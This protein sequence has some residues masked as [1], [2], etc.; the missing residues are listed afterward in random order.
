MSLDEKLYVNKEKLMRYRYILIAILGIIIILL[1]FIILIVA[2]NNKT[3]NENDINNNSVSNYD[4]GEKQEN[5]NNIKTNE[6]KNKEDKPIIIALEN[7]K[8][9]TVV[10]KNKE[11]NITGVIYL[12]FDDGPTESSTPKILDILERNNIKAT[13][14][15]IGYNEE[16]AY[17]LKR[18]QKLGQTIA[19]HGYTH[20]YS[21]VYQSADACVEN[22]RKIQQQVNQTT[23][24]TSN[25]IRF[26]GGSSNTIS[27]K[28]CKGVM[29]ELSQRVLNEGF[30][31]FDW[32]V[33]S[34]DA[35]SARNSNDIYNN[36]ISGIQKHQNSVVLMHDFANNYKTIDALQGIIDYGKS[37][38]YEFR[39]ITGETEMVTHSV[40]N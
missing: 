11:E 1:I 36:V 38:G 37:N 32:N 26:P 15:V 23:G 7:N 5:E 28:Y 14:F 24:I 9:E 21:Q 22:F 3:K 13:F 25:I 4:N 8:E 19:L 16:S 10:E 29:T 40:N 30:R 2:S 31:Y 18:E 17:L 33:D 20:T 27:R 35:G 6:L 12:T 39:A 34:E